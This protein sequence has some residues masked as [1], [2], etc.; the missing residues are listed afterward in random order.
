[1]RVA[2]QRRADVDRMNLSLWERIDEGQRAMSDRAAE[3]QYSAWL[4]VRKSIANELRSGTADVIVHRSHH[5]KRIEID[6]A[7]IERAGGD[8]T[9]PTFTTV[10]AGHAMD[11]HAD[12]ILRQRQCGI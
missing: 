11:I 7:V 5:A 9:R 12:C 4:E 3:I 8:I 10:T 1:M 2:Q 6:A